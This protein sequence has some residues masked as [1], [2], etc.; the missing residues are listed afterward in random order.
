MATDIKSSTALVQAPVESIYARFSNPENLKAIIDAA[1]EGRIPADKLEQIKQIQVTPDSITVPG[2]PTGAVTL[3]LVDCREPSLIRLKAMDVPIDLVLEL[4]L[5]PVTAESAETQ[6][7][8]V[9]DI[10]MMLRPMLKGPLQQVA[11]KVNEMV[12]S[13][14]Y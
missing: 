2:G 9:A 11:D 13:I 14:P 10:P 4:H 6:V 5:K 8:I 12:A 3:K 1:P 7:Q